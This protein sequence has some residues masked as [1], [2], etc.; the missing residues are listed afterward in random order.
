MTRWITPVLLVVLAGCDPF[1]FGPDDAQVCTLEYRAYTVEVVGPDGAPAVGLDARTVVVSTGT[2]LG[3]PDG[4]SGIEGTYY[5]A[6]DGNA[7]E[8]AEGETRLRFTA[9]GDGLRASADY[10]FRFDGCHVFRE[11]GPTQITAERL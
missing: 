5:V 7:G 6:T 1:G 2:V 8:L 9:E 11:S 3:N 10:V 4:P